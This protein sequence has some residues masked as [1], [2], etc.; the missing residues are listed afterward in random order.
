MT[1][2]IIKLK[3][4]YAPSEASD[5]TRVLID[6]LWPR[7]V[8]KAEADIDLWLKELAP[9]TALRKWFDH[10]PVKWEEFKSRYRVELNGAEGR[11]ILHKLLGMARD[12]PLTLVFA[13]KDAEHNNA[14][15]L[16]EILESK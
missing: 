11:A 3:R 13:A 6:R 15:V 10:D 1:K 14:V 12:G 2:P 9:S 16:K 5:G 7:G 4:A 8:S